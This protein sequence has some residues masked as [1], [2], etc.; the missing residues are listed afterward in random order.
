[1]WDGI[2]RFGVPLILV[3]ILILLLLYGGKMLPRLGSQLGR[4]ARKPYRQAKWMWSS[5]AGTEE[6]AMRAEK[7]YGR[8]CAR[9]FAGQFAAAASSADQ[10]LV[11]AVGSRLADAAKDAR[12]EFR[13]KAVSSPTANAYALPGGFIFITQSLLDLCAR[14]RDEMAFFLGHEIGHIVRGH[15]RDQLTA[16]TIL[17]AV[18]ARIS[19][20]GR[21]LREALGKGY[22]RALELEADRES[23]RLAA[24]AGFDPRASL[25]ALERLA[26]IAP[27]NAGFAEYFSSHPPLSERIQELKTC[28]GA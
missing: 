4:Q 18:T 24:A 28:C 3:L 6:E 12:R 1:M 21:I 27:D 11:A 2:G 23:V 25:R 19:G 26:G 14:D 22:S 17:N 13:F 8:E 9:E 5:F 20:A 16:S 15:A 10:D 7:E